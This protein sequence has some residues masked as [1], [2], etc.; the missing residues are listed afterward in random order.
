M[1]SVIS[2][3]LDILLKLNYKINSGVI[4]RWGMVLS[5]CNDGL[6]Y[7]FVCLENLV[8]ILIIKLSFVLS[9]KLSVV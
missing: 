3:I 9:K 4:V 5:I 8:K 2:K 6:R 1:L 7:S